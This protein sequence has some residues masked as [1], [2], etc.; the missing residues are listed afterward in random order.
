M[1]RSFLGNRWV[2]A[3]KNLGIGIWGSLSVAQYLKSICKPWEF[4]YL[5]P[6]NNNLWVIKGVNLFS[7]NCFIMPITHY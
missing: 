6:Q 5:V 2:I 3:N 1:Q 7:T 4:D